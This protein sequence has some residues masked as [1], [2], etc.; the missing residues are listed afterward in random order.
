MSNPLKVFEYNGVKFADGLFRMHD[1][2]GFSLGDSLIQCKR[3]GLTP[4]LR[5]FETDAR[6]AGWSEDKIARTLK[7]AQ[8]DS[9][10]VT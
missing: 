3:L 4:C 9:M 8:M 1:E 5:Q 7:E 2:Q 10:L 6:C